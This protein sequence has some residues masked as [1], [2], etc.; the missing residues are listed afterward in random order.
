MIFLLWKFSS[1]KTYFSW[2]STASSVF[3]FSAVVS[4]A[5]EI[6]STDDKPSSCSI[7]Q[8][9]ISTVPSVTTG[10]T[11]SSTLFEERGTHSMDSSR[12]SSLFALSCDSKHS[13]SVKGEFVSATT[14]SLSSLSCFTLFS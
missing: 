14:R 4:T 7:T 1:V 2:T 5:P 8:G 6:S 10:P 3:P 11:K 9:K 13:K 12:F